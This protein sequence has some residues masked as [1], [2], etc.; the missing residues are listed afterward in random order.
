[1]HKPKEDVMLSKLSSGELRLL[2]EK[3]KDTIIHPNREEREKING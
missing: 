2:A 3:L 1:M